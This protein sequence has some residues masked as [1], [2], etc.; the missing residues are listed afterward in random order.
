MW[1]ILAGVDEESPSPVMICCH[2]RQKTQ[3]LIKDV[4]GHAAPFIA[5]SPLFII[6]LQWRE[7]VLADSIQVSSLQ[8]S[9]T[10]A[11]SVCLHCSLLLTTLTEYR[12]RHVLETESRAEEHYQPNHR[13]NMLKPR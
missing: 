5:L 9:Q 3:L 6:L 4:Q 13:V 8:M 1:S 11:P 10:P 12:H 2:R 7:F